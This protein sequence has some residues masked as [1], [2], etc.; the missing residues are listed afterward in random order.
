MVKICMRLLVLLPLRIIMRTILSS[1]MECFI[2]RENEEEVNAS[3]YYWVDVSYAPLCSD[4][5]RKQ[6][7]PHFKAGVSQQ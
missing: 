7:E 1:E 6:R 2:L 5:Y 4:A 3:P